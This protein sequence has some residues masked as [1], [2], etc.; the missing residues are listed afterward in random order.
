MFNYIA[1]EVFSKLHETIKE[2]LVISSILEQFS[3]E[4][5]NYVLHISNSKE[6][7]KKIV[8]LN[9]F[10]INLDDEEK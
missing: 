6:I 1:E 9:L 8:S 4:V 3:S 7:I 10:I 5:C 2:F